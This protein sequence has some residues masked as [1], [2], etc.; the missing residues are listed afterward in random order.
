M[1]NQTPAQTIAR[2]AIAA[3]G[4]LGLVVLAACGNGDT[5]L[6]PG[7]VLDREDVQEIV[8][9]EAAN[10]ATQP[11]PGLSP[12]QVDEIVRTILAELPEPEPGLSRAEVDEI[13]QTA[14]A[15]IPQPEPRLSRDEVE[16]VARSTVASIPP[17]SA[18][19]E[20]TKFFVENAISLYETQGLQAT[21]DHYSRVE[22]IDGQWY[23]FII[24]DDDRVIAHPDVGRIGLDLK[25]WVGVDANGYNFA[26]EMLSATEKGKWVTYVYQNPASGSLTPVDLDKVDLK[27]TW[28]VRHDG[29]LFGSGWY[30]DVD[31]FTKDLVADIVDL[32]ST[33]GLKGTAEALHSDTASI[34]AGAAESAVAYNASGAV[35]GEWSLFIVDENG[36]T[37]LHLNPAMIG[38]QIDDLLGVDTSGIDDEGT[39]LTSESMRIWV[40]RHDDWLFGAGWHDDETRR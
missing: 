18:A 29:L 4:I 35:Q 33:V 39:W 28:V 15:S 26:P 5:G 21:L 23:V 31:Q 34:L 7:D 40:V 16:R 19:A 14:L 9:A 12:A 36:A 22:S 25:G 3:S 1:T 37:A 8:R 38:E 2:I 30:I 27:N 24:D 6:D 13:V 11:E 20:Y 32:F 10:A 17:K